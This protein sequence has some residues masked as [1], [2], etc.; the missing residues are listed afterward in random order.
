[1]RLGSRGFSLG[2]IEKGYLL[3]DNSRE[4]A[5]ILEFSSSFQIHL[6]SKSQISNR[7]TSQ[8]RRCLSRQRDRAFH[9]SNLN[10][11]LYLVSTDTGDR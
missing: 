6:W 10:L 8:K 4:S 2:A 1:M 9:S 11:Q 3:S 5:K 7:L